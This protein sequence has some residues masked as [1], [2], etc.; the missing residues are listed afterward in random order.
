[1]DRHNN[2]KAFE[3][4]ARAMLDLG[5]KVKVDL[6]IGLPG[7]TVDSV[8][9]GIDYIHHSGL[10]SQVQVFNLAILP[11]TSFRQEAAQLGPALSRPSAVLRARNADAFDP[12]DVRLDGRG[13]RRF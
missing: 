8:R 3:R 5:I 2:L 11:G 1:M 13:G 7:D 4:G 9:R 6:I 12:A 10:Y